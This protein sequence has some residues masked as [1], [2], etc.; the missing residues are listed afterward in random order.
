MYNVVLLKWITNYMEWK[1]V[2]IIMAAERRRDEKL[3]R[4]RE[5]KIKQRNKKI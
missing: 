4:R 1:N 3:E 5:R 2:S